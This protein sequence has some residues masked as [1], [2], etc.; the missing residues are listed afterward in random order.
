MCRT[1]GIPCEMFFAA[2]CL[3]M[4]VYSSVPKDM[5]GHPWIV[6]YS[7]TVFTSDKELLDYI[8]IAKV[9]MFY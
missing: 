2:H 5:E 6:N 1:V 7:K 8:K 3:H 4:D 9:R